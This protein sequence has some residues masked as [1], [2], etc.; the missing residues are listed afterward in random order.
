MHPL[1]LYHYRTQAAA[2]VDLVVE[3]RAGQIV[4]IEV[5]AS[6]TISSA[7]WKGLDILGEEMGEKMV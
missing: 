6:E 7:D 5:K 4:G 2:E 1:E 3:N